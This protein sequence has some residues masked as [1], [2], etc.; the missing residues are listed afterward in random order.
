MPGGIPA[1]RGAR[2]DLD[3]DDSAVPRLKDEVDL[4][5]VTVSEVV[6]GHRRIRQRGGLGEFAENEGLDETAERGV[7]GPAE[8]LRGRLDE[9]GGQAGIS[10]ICLGSLG[11][12]RCEV[13]R[14]R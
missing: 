8:G 14:P 12:P 11:D 4:A 1:G 10:E 2:L 13:A 6:D 3:G 7:A 5:A 9:V